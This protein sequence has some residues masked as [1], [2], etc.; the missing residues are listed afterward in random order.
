MNDAPPQLNNCVDVPSSPHLLT[1][2]SN[3][4]EYC[5][6]YYTVTICVNIMSTIKILLLKLFKLLYN[7]P[8]VLLEGGQLAQETVANG[9]VPGDESADNPLQVQCTASI[10]EMVV[11]P[12]SSSESK[13]A[14]NLVGLPTLCRTNTENHHKRD[15]D[16][17]DS[18]ERKK[19]AMDRLRKVSACNCLPV[20]FVVQLCDNV[21]VQNV[22]CCEY[23]F[24]CANCA[25][26]NV[27]AHAV[28]S[29]VSTAIVL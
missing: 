18:E 28:M 2:Q 26:H 21:N 12:S 11:N 3:S 6:V 15:S 10:G 16:E 19:K 4:G 1:H 14:R 25:V 22:Y 13:F 5:R 23:A 20:A 24:C 29:F 8:Y 9:G 7:V 17:E 27:Y